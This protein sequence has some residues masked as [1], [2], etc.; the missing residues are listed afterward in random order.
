MPPEKRRGPLAKGTSTNWSEPERQNP[1]SS[2]LKISK[3]HLRVVSH[4]LRAVAWL[5]VHAE[6]RSLAVAP[7]P[8]TVYRGLENL[9][10]QPQ[11]QGNA[12]SRMSYRLCSSC[13]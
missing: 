8:T 4:Q 3:R 5:D 2:K 9:A 10:R 6:D 11:R 12:T 1:P 7:E 13:R